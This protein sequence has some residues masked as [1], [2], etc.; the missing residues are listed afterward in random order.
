M[1]PYHKGW[2]PCPYTS[3][4]FLE[5]QCIQRHF[6]FLC[7]ELFISALK[8]SGSGAAIKVLIEKMKS[9]DISALEA[10]NIFT[11]FKANVESPAII[12]ELVVRRPSLC[13]DETRQSV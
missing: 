1:K 13:N 3:L 4:F 8:A 6:Y 10:A 12:P 9:N 5:P 11:T 2:I 7:R